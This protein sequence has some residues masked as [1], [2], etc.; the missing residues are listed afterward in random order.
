M[1][2][3]LYISRHTR[4]DIMF[5]VNF[6]CQ[7]CAKPFNIHWNAAKRILCYL[8]ST[9]EHFLRI[10]PSN[11]EGIKCYSDA[12]WA[13]C[14]ETGLSRTGGVFFYN[15]SLV[16]AHSH[17]SY[18]ALC[19]SVQAIKAPNLKLHNLVVN[20]TINQVSRPPIS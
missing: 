16:I 7:F 11:N 2:S 10:G 19:I 8:Y 5:A 9:K 4:P 18:S 14:K 12:T 1:G 3:L 6:L 15:G 13:N 20:L 17:L